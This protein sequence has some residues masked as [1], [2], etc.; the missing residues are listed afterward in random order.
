[1]TGFYKS[2][3]VNHFRLLLYSVY[4][5]QSGEHLFQQLFSQCKGKGALLA[6]VPGSNT[7]NLQVLAKCLNGMSLKSKSAWFNTIYT[8]N[9]WPHANG[10]CAN[11]HSYSRRSERCAQAFVC[12]LVTQVY[13]ST[14]VKKLLLLLS[15]LPSVKWGA[16]NI[17]FI[18][19]LAVDLSKTCSGL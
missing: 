8:S 3:N 15:H 19:L 12:H 11:S 18:Y 2:C 10:T 13:E 7:Y 4:S 14:T 16:N 17:L 6:A 1:M 5:I 9:S